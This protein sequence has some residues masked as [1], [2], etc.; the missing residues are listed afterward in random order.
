MALH[1]NKYLLK[2]IFISSVFSILFL[3]CCTQKPFVMWGD[4]T[5]FSYR[6]SVYKGQVTIE[7]C[8]ITTVDSLNVVNLDSLSNKIVYPNYNESS[9]V[10]FGVT[11]FFKLDST[12]TAKDIRFHDGS[13]GDF[14]KA[15]LEGLRNFK[16]MFNKETKI[17]DLDGIL[18][19]VY[20]TYPLKENIN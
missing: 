13:Y 17:K 1:I 9:K 12:R 3:G 5:P 16:F 19:F 20:K 8:Q 15:I 10:Q 11:I 4:C 6:P 2:V 7:F 18:T 14:G